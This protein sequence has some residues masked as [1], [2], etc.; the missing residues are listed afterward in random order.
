MGS[1]TGTRSHKI[2][3]VRGERG[4]WMADAAD[5]WVD[6]E[7]GHERMP[8]PAMRS[9]AEGECFEREFQ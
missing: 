4:A 9:V 6:A 7:A 5:D 3:D 2:V 8:R 1:T